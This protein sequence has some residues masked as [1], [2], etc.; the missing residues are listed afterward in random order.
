LRKKFKVTIL[1][2]LLVTMSG[3]QAL[4]AGEG[5]SMRNA[6]LLSLVLPGAGQQYL[7]YHRRARAMYVAEAAVWSV[8]AYYRV[9]GGN[10]EDR[11]KE[12]ARLFAG[13]SGERDDEYYKTIAYYTTSTDYNT[14]VMR[15]ARLRFPFD[16]ENQKAYFDR[17]AYFGDDAWEWES[18]K[19]QRD[20]RDTRVASKESYRRSVLTTGFAL[21]NRVVSMVDIYLSFKLGGY[22][23]SASRPRL[24]AD[25]VQGQGFR[26]YISTPF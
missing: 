5:R 1:L 9:Q 25:Q 26:L 12:M 19:K 6:L 15:E 11:Y 3:G 22:A 23:E 24:M 4:G 14:D 16:R 17:N 21:L 7:G 2:A 20:Y 10:R 18:L 8:F 13:I